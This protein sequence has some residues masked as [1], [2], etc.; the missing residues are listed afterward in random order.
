MF[1]ESQNYSQCLMVLTSPKFNRILN[2]SLFL[3]FGVARI[4]FIVRSNIRG[5]RTGV[6]NKYFTSSDIL[7]KVKKELRIDWSNVC[8]LRTRGSGKLFVNNS[9]NGQFRNIKK[10]T[11]KSS[12]ANMKRNYFHVRMATK[13]KLSLKN[14]PTGPPWNQR[15]QSA[16][17]FLLH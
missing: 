3:L 14:S 11:K 10:N 8:F 13:Y 17:K 7:Q 6:V 4:R 1:N 15:D 16:N 2:N 9:K 12:H 5:L